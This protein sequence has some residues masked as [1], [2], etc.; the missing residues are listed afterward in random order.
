MLPAFVPGKRVSGLWRLAAALAC[1]W[2]LHLIVLFLLS[3][4]FPARDAFSGKGVGQHFSALLRV[5]GETGGIET[6]HPAAGDASKNSLSPDVGIG[7]ASSAETIGAVGVFGAGPAVADG[8][9]LPGEG[10]FQA[11]QLTSRPQV[12]GI[13]ALDA[14]EIL[15]S[16]ASGKLVLDLWINEAGAVVKIAVEETSLPA[17]VTLSIA[18]A[19][20]KALFK[21]GEIDGQVVGS[22][23]KIE[24]S[25]QDARLPA[26]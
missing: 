17:S 8:F 10:F 7:G 11:N 25:I 12:L 3:R 16:P 2:L 23:M 15:F 6:E 26:R 18:E 13:V 24:V 1:S 14:P 20:R 5:V 22:Q 19:F 21:P 9:L 4:V